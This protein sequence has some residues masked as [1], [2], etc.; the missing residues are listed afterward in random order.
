MLEFIGDE[1]ACVV[2]FNSQKEKKNHLANFHDK[3]LLA[4]FF[5]LVS[6]NY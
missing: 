6:A 2:L 1:C 5:L 3:K 4:D